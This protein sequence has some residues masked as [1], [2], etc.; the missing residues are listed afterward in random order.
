M[1]AEIKETITKLLWETNLS[2]VSKSQA[3]I[4]RSLR[5][6][7]AAASDLG[8]GLLSLRAMSLVY[9][10]LLS[11]V[12]LLA[13]SFSVLKGFGVHNQ[14]EP[15]L[16]S[17]LDP[18]GEKGVRISQQIISFVDNM[19]VGVLGSV[20]MLFLIFTVLSLVKKIETAFN[21]T[22]HI[23][24]T[25]NIF[26]RFSNYLSVILI[27][28]FLLF[29]AAGV[30]ASFN[31]STVLEKISAIEP[32]GTMI[33]FAGELLPYI[34]TIITFTVMYALI[35]NTKVRFTS[36]LLG[37]IV[38]TILWKSIGTL[39]TMFIVNSTNYTAIYSTFAIMIIFMI[40]IY[41]SWLIVLTGASISYYYQNQ[42][43]ISNKSQV[44]RLS[45]R[46]REKLALT[47]MQLIATNFHHNEPAW[48]LKELARKTA[49]SEPA[50]LL[51]LTALKK[52]KLLVTTGD[53]KNHFLPSQSLEN[54]TIEMIMNAARNAEETNNL[55][56][57]DVSTVQQV[58][59][60]ILDIEN[61][62]SEATKGKTLKDLV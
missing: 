46:L 4:T 17:L 1:F 9:T 58:N 12:P 7:Y 61:A 47:V 5:I 45:C 33:L 30:T 60:V 11:M 21:F 38:A 56:A 40:W 27:G 43:R 51:I 26:Q 24:V 14:L 62:V 2:K 55:R 29:T 44:F 37:A 20:G 16:I 54:I 23:S 8:G 53:K 59:D 35:P 10:T 22:W 3:F 50:L 28:P 41:V 13:V 34:L 39:F 19:K 48:T 42:D 31:S 32:F 6:L 15:T 25:R 57:D 36:A 52:D 18:L 49:I